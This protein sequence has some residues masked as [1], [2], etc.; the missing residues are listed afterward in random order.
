MRIVQDLRYGVRVWRKSP[1]LS[2]VAV[3]TLAIGIGTNT[4]VFSWI[5]SLLLH[6][7]PGA[8][9]PGELASFETLTPSGE[10]VTTSYE[11]YRDYRDHLTLV[12][13]L[14]IAQPRALSVGEQEHSER[15]WG[16]L[17]S[18]NY[19]SILRV[20]PVVGRTFSPDEYGDKAGGYPVVVIGY[21]LWQRLF[22]SDP[23]VIGRTVRVNGQ[24]LTI[25]GV[26]QKEFRGTIPGLAFEI[27]V[28]AIMGTQLNVMPDWMIRDRQTRSFV[29]IARLKPGVT[30]ERARTEI[31]SLANHLATL[32]PGTNRGMS[33]TVLPIWR[34]H[35]GAQSLMMK[36]L[37]ILMAVCGIVLLIVCANVASLLLARSTTRQK[38]FSVRMAI[39]AGRATL[40]R[41]IMME[42]LVLVALGALAGVPLA[43]W[44]QGA[45]GYLLPPGVLPVTFTTRLS[46]DVFAFVLL[47]CAV[48]CIA[49][50]I[51]PAL[52]VTR[53]DLAEQLNKGGRSGTAGARSQR[54]RAALVA[55]EVALALIAIICAGLFGRSFNLA[56]RINP[57]FDPQHVAVAFPYLS[58]GEYPVPAR[59]EF[60][61]RL[62]DRILSEP[63]VVSATYADVVP[64]GFGGDPWEDLQI[65]GYVPSPAENM[66]IYRNLVAPGYFDLMRIPLLDGRDFTELDDE[67]SQPVMIV[68]D[69]FARRFLPGKN[70]IGYK[71]RGFGRS[72]NIVGVV[73]DS[74]YRRLNEPL[75]PYFYVP[76]RQVYRADLAVAFYIRVAGDARHAIPLLRREIRSMDPN[77]G[78]F[79]AMPLTEYIAA[80]LFAQKMAASLLAVLGAVALVLAVV[81]LYGVIAFMVTLRT[82]ELG[83]RMA[84]GARPADVLGM[85]LR[86]GMAVTLAGV[87]AGIAASLAITRLASGLLINVSATDPLVFVA[88]PALLALVAAVASLA[89]AYRA[90]RID[91]NVALRCQ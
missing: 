78:V 11:D 44:M 46:G 7:L 35:F 10:A 40:V 74:K 20:A 6:P 81:G 72:F 34:G 33:A 24:Q 2:L 75:Q 3:L 73:R 52:H 63:G 30:L 47:I 45:L 62:R 60:C 38:E 1:G 5:D 32:Y 48:A 79:D 9:Q 31:A 85:V 15:V 50:G 37:Q 67:N 27:W 64:L 12:S 21:G 54:T 77:V 23:A 51:W 58:T 90:A 4:T 19:F 55:A 53:R 18:G 88:A 49:S 83:I 84:L 57:G 42:N 71:V 69:A 66:K 28:P 61:R 16:E 76:F 41:Q 82:Q 70:P 91:P 56:S 22:N 17:V 39:G 59:K 68:S 43:F 29:G 36:P 86:Q 25:V 89:P 26:A 14:A 65:Q 13:G 8:A 87:A 80:S